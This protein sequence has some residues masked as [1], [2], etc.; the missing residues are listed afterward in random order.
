MATPPLRRDLSD[1]DIANMLRV[2]MTPRQC[3]V[4][5]HQRYYDGTIYDGRPGFLDN[6]SEKPL[7]ERAPC[8]LY[9]AVRSAAQSFATLCLGEG[10]FPSITS[11]TSED[12][13]VLDPRFGL[14]ESD[15]KIIDGG[16]QKIADQA[17]LQTVMQQLLEWSAK[18]GSVA[19]VASVVKGRLRAALV[20]P[21]TCTPTFAPDDPDE[22]IKLEIAYRSVDR[23]FDAA[24]KEYKR[25]VLQHRRV[26]DDQSDIEYEPVEVLNDKDFPVPSTPKKGAAYKHSFGF[27]PVVWYRYLAPVA[28]TQDVDGKPMHW[29][30]LNLI[31]SINFSLSQRFRA[32]LYC[33]DPQIVETGV[34]D[35]EMRMPM[36][37]ASDARQ[38][39]VDPSGWNAPL[40]EKRSGRTG[41]RRRKKGAGTVWRYTSPDAKVYLLTLPGDALKT[42]FEDAADNIG[43]L[44]EALGYVH[45][46]PK[47][48]TGSGDVSGKT[49]QV[50]FRPTVQVCNRIREDFGR[51]CLLPVLNMLLRIVARLGGRGMYLPGAEKLAKVVARFEQQVDGVGATSWFPPALRLAWPDYFEPSDND[52]A[53]K[54]QNGVAAKQ[55]NAITLRTLVQHIKPIFPDIQNV[56]QYVKALLEEKQEEQKREQEQLHAAMKAMGGAAPGAPTPFG[57]KG[58]KVPPKPGAPNG[59]PGSATAAR[60]A[61]KAPAKANDRSGGRAGAA[62]AAGKG[63]PARGAAAAA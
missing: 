6:S 62:R 11:G 18:S 22:V 2:A 20:D 31:D 15:S 7:T 55:A 58:G 48:I 4:D 27:C 63:K 41:D 9:P 8:V 49:L 14:N 52:E 45:V 16:I 19:V 32:A 44:Q 25:R 24:A 5:L 56:D 47:D 59:K 51:M 29:G 57:M 1:H 39:S 35:D 50:L 46:D 38:Q 53:T 43:K 23:Y 26:I 33:G 30:L 3:D 21:R 13:S 28:A 12:D 37:R 10:H 36:G 42:L 60:G 61:G 17:R 40:T 34:E 54:I